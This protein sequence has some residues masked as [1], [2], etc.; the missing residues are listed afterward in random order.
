MVSISLYN[1]LSERNIINVEVQHGSI[2]D[3][4]LFIV[5]INDIL[6]ALNNLNINY[7]FILFANYRYIGLNF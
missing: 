5:Y 2:F 6:I 1:E 4:I 3:P 7:N